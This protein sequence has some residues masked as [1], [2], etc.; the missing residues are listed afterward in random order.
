MATDKRSI[1]FDPELLREAEELASATGESLSGFVNSALL[2]RLRATRGLALLAEDDAELGPV[3][4]DVKLA[5]AKQWR[6]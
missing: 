1:S 6:G 2:D 3:P 5:V 4:D